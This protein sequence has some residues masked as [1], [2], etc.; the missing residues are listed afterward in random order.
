MVKDSD[1]LE[2][3]YCLTLSSAFPNWDPDFLCNGRRARDIAEHLI[4]NELLT[5]LAATES[6]L[7]EF[8]ENFG[9]R[10][11]QMGMKN[12]LWEP[13]KDCGGG[14]NALQRAKDLIKN[15]NLSSLEAVE[16]IQNN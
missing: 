6:V 14:I 5:A 13:N 8:P 9:I 11:N 2:K 12:L 10:M 16:C 4:H 15:N 3:S 1:I 7:V